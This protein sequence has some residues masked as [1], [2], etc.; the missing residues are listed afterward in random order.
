MDQSVNTVDLISIDLASDGVL[1]FF[2]FV[3]KILNNVGFGIES[4]VNSIETVEDTLDL[5]A[6]LVKV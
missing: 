1:T 6:V 4:V 3:R 5:L 2:D